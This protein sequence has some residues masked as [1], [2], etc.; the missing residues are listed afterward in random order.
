MKVELIYAIFAAVAVAIPHGGSQK[1]HLEQ[2]SSSSM[3]MPSMTSV[4]KPMKRSSAT[5][6]FTPTS[7]ASMHVTTTDKPMKAG[8]RMMMMMF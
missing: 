6:N 1:H 3:S 7:S 2:S 4:T 5:A 8:D